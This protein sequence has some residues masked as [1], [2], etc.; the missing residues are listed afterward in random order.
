MVRYTKKRKVLHKRTRKQGGAAK[1][2]NMGAFGELFARRGAPPPPH[3]AVEAGAPNAAAEA[4]LA[5]A[6]PN[7]PLDK[8]RKMIKM[9]QPE[10]AIRQK[11]TING[12]SQANINIIFPPGNAVVELKK[13]TEFTVDELNIL[14]DYLDKSI[15]IEQALKSKVDPHI[16]YSDVSEKEIRKAADEISKPEDPVKREVVRPIIANGKVNANAMK[17][18]LQLRIL[19][20]VQ[21]DISFFTKLTGQEKAALSTVGKIDEDIKTL[22]NKV[23]PSNIALIKRKRAENKKISIYDIEAIL[24]SLKDI[25]EKKERIEKTL[26][27]YKEKFDFLDG[28]PAVKKFKVDMDGPLPNGWFIEVNSQK[29]TMIYRNKYTNSIQNERPTEEALRPTELPEGWGIGEDETDFWYVN[30]ITNRSQWE[31]PTEPA[32]LFNTTGWTPVPEPDGSYT[33][34]MQYNKNNSGEWF[35]RRNADSIWYENPSN[36]S[37]VRYNEPPF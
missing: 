2:G 28:N 19:G 12:K 31:I 35:V 6:A 3:P 23:I 33:W 18:N 25:D 11:M 21:Q 16:L 10:G 9:G 17:R 20:A 14:K 24:Q 36:G 15:I 37:G 7:D 29:K 1:L 34:Y 13:R 8:Y 30:L 32:Q 26:K 22:K 27:P 4:P 5:T